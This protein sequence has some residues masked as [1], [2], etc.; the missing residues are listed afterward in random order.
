MTGTGT[1]V[2]KT[3]FTS[4]ALRA[5]REARVDAVGFKPVVCGDREDAAALW[6]ASDGALD[7][8]VLYGLTLYCCWRLAS[9]NFVVQGR[10]SNLVDYSRVSILLKCLISGGR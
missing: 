1:E 10:I 8:D 2:G 6:D 4:L 7:L 9:V 3:Y 5:L